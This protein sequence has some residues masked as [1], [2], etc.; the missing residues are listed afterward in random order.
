M[1]TDRQGKRTEGRSGEDDSAG[2]VKP[3]DSDKAA[4]KL[5]QMRRLDYLAWFAKLQFWVEDTTD[6]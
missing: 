3:N 4:A 5:V 2:D 6:A 1:G